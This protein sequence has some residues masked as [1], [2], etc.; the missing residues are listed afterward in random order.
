MFIRAANPIWYLPDLVG[1]PLN[2][3]YYAFFLTN[4]IPYLPQNVYRDPNGVTV[5][6]GN[7]VQFEPGGTLPNNL[8]FDPTLVYRIEI[9]HGNTQADELIYEV[10][11]FLPESDQSINNNLSV[12]PEGNQ[13]TNGRFSIVSFTNPYTITTAGTYN[14]APGWDLVLTGVGTTTL[15]QNVYSGIQTVDPSVN[16]VTFSLQIANTGWSTANLVQ[17]FENNGNIWSEGAVA[18]SLTARA[19]GTPENLSL[20]YSPSDPPGSGTVI[21]NITG[22]GTG[23]FEVI[24]GVNNI[25]ASTSNDLSDVA[26]VDMIIQLPTTGTVEITNFQV[27]GQSEPF[28]DPL[29]APIPPYQ[30][31]SEERNL[32]HL[33]NVYANEL[34]IKPKESLLTGWN[35]PLNPWQFRDPALADVTSQCSYITDQ[36]ILYQEAA[37]QFQAG[38][39]AANQRYNLE[40]KAVAAATDTRFALIQYIDPT[41]INP[42]WGYVVSS[43]VRARIFTSHS[44]EVKIKARLIYRS[45]LPSALSSTE[46]IGSWAGTDPVFSAGW[47]AI[48]PLNDPEYLL[49]NEYSTDET[50]TGFSY[51]AFSFDQFNLPNNNAGVNTLTLGIVI[52]TTGDLDS[53]MGTE[54]SINFDKISLIPSHFAAD[55]LPETYD[56]SL[57]KCQF[58]YEKSYAPEDLPE[59]TTLAGTRYSSGTVESAGGNA[60]FI[61]KTFEVV[62]NTIKRATPVYPTLSTTANPIQLYSPQN[63]TPDTI[64]VQILSAGTPVGTANSD[65]NVGTNYT[66]NYS[67]PKSVV[68]TPKT[69]GPVASG[70]IFAG[71]QEGV[72]LYQYTVDCTLGGPVL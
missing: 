52:Y 53:S 29:V 46:P 18:M 38:K 56:E 30:Q 11:N 10:N 37:S 42:Y 6:T 20:I 3:E 9:R 4:T 61:Y 8:Y 65:E 40:I 32:D 28:S 60:D 69:L 66:L 57:R 1:E 55:A 50:L 34:I 31:E 27:M 51:P 44:T 72:I 62:F 25:P 21:A 68:Y 13:A 2:D 12:F 39:G 22:L 14:I 16:D 63:G 7:I 67:S 64:R 36:T 59:S 58:Y 71:S 43:L 5:W 41:T 23:P 48:A 24:E 15:Q 17:R 45:T 70:Q 19:I 35:F 47:T 49:L 26:Y 33:F 54:D